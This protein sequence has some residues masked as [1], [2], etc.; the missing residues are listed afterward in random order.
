MAQVAPPSGTAPRVDIPSSLAGITGQIA[1]QTIQESPPTALRV[2]FNGTQGVVSLDR[3]TRVD[4]PVIFTGFDGLPKDVVIRAGTSSVSF[5]LEPKNLFP[6]FVSATDPTLRTF[7]V[8]ASSLTLSDLVST[9]GMFPASTLAAGNPVHDLMEVATTSI[10]LPAGTMVSA[11]E[12]TIGG[13][14]PFLVQAVAGES[15]SYVVLGSW[16]AADIQIRNYN[17]GAWDTHILSPGEVM[18]DSTGENGLLFRALD[19]FF[20]FENRS[21]TAAALP[22]PQEWF[23]GLKDARSLAAGPSESGQRGLPINLGVAA[24]DFDFY[25]A[26]TFTAR[27]EDQQDVTIGSTGGFGILVPIVTHAKA[28]LYADRM[29]LGVATAGWTDLSGYDGSNAPD[30]TKPLEVRWSGF[31]GQFSDAPA[32]T[33]LIW[34]DLTGTLADGFKLF[35]A[36]DQ[37]GLT[38][39]AGE[40]GFRARG[41]DWVGNGSHGLQI[42]SVGDLEMTASRVSQVGATP[43]AGSVGG[44]T[45]ESQGKV[46]LGGVDAADQVRLEAKV[47]TDTAGTGAQN[48]AVI[49]TG[50]SLELRNVVIR[51]FDGTRLEKITTAADGT[52]T[53]AGRVL[54]SGSSVR[55]FKIK[56][57][58]GAAV[59]A[60]AKIQMMAMADNGSLAGEMMV[61]GTLPVATKLARELDNTITDARGGVAV[62][63]RDIQLAADRVNLNGANLAAM[64]SIAIRANTVLVQNSFMTVVQNS[65]MINMYVQQGLVNRNYGT[66]V[67]GQANFAGNNT[68]Q[69]GTRPAIVINSQGTLDAA[70]GSRLYDTTHNLPPQQGS[71]NVL[72][73]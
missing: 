51:S 11:H 31:F 37:T 66:V 44:L 3:V 1:G 59:N 42:T 14:Q 36:P 25:A 21:P 68:F 26:G 47:S 48:L 73:L 61:E 46:K 56:E 45:L 30:D 50:D 27:P 2:T 41:M 65:G 19:A 38:L 32:A 43:G 22:G 20:H 5:A 9:A 23:A 7:L 40:L 24:Q 16:T 67:A 54:V 33:G 55:D 29:D 18:A 17:A 63:A 28:I 34:D 13:G 6:G 62:Q 10:R 15:R 71:I 53:I 60:D 4:R 72:A 57:L 39:A 52:Q 35:A 12:I 58:V 64:N 70:F 69:I 8:A 49:R